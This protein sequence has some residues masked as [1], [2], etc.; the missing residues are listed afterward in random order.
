MFELMEDPVEETS[1]APETLWAIV[2]LFG[3]QRIA[4]KL[5]E[6]TMGGGTFV[7]VD[8]PAIARE[9]APEIPGF[10]KLFGNGA[11]YAINFV[12]ER[13]ARIAAAGIKATPIGVWD[14]RE[15]LDAMGQGAR[16]NLGLL[17]VRTA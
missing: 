6:Q 9:G 7:R 14:L 17:P 4:G 16:E 3:H 1:K 11:I 15:G 8:V 12:D 2:E 5:S 10:T 13:T